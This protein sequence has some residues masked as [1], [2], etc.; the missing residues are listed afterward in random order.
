[1]AYAYT[2]SHISLKTNEFSSLLTTWYSSF[3]IQLLPI[4]QNF[5][6]LLTR[7]YHRTW[8]GSREMFEKIGSAWVRR[9]KACVA[10]EG[11]YFEN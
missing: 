6:A 2:T 1:M 11:G 9:L 7:K 8:A 3:S 5:L 4:P 10:A